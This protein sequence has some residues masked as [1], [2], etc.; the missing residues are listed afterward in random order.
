MSL[1]A[2]V[3]DPPLAAYYAWDAPHPSTSTQVVWNQNRLAVPAVLVPPDELRRRGLLHPG[4]QQQ[5]A[6]GSSLAVEPIVFLPVASIPTLKKRRRL[7][8]APPALRAAVVGDSSAAN[9]G[10]MAAALDP[11]LPA[12]LAAQQAS[13]GSGEVHQPADC[14]GEQ[15]CPPVLPLKP[16]QKDSPPASP[17]AAQ[18]GLGEGIAPLYAQPASAYGAASE[19]LEPEAGADCQP[20]QQEQQ[21]RPEQPGA[22]CGGDLVEGLLLVSARAA[23]CGRFPLNGTYFQARGGHACLLTSPPPQPPRRCM[24]AAG[25]L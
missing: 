8:A 2:C 7:L 9:A 14:L 24:G 3:H 20:A 15:L 25:T 16:E 18:P 10:A 23:L 12:Q 17:P 21:E 5:F 19:P 4:Y 13:Q 1:H 22:A 11:S 6:E